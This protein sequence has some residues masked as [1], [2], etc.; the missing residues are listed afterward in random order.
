M[1]DLVSRAVFALVLAVVVA[2]LFVIGIGFLFA[3]L[4]LTL[5]T[6]Y[7]PPAAALLTGLAIIGGA[8]LIFLIGR[9]LLRRRR[10][11]RYGAAAAPPTAAA[12]PPGAT[13]LM[14][15]DMAT[16]LGRLSATLFRSHPKGAA[17]SA[18]VTGFAV[19]ISPALRRKLGGFFR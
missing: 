10:R 16:E 6:T 9:F 14:T 11:W 4:F 15:A 7:A 18:F 19:G 17:T 5:S 2:L 12:P 13:G 3:A 8:L 1:T